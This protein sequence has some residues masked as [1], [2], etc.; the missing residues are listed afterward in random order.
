MSAIDKYKNMLCYMYLDDN[1]SISKKHIKEVI[2][3]L[4]KK[5]PT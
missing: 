4:L 3:W 1:I 2:P 5:F